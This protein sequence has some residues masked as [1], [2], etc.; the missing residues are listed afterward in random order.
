MQRIKRNLSPLS[1]ITDFLVRA[2]VQQ[3]SIRRAWKIRI[4]QLLDK[5][6]DNEVRERGKLLLLNALLHLVQQSLL[7][8]ITETEISLLCPG[9][10]P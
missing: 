9:K 1:Q 2:F 10:Q 6:L 5:R 3:N 8:V 4:H 7:S